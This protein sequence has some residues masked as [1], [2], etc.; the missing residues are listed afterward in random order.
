MQQRRALEEAMRVFGH[1]GA[2]QTLDMQ[3]RCAEPRCA[4]LGHEACVFEMEW[5]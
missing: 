2:L 1:E 4:C 3:G 5:A